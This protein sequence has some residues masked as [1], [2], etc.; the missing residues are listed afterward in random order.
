MQKQAKE[1]Y[2]KAKR[3]NERQP[4]SKKNIQSVFFVTLFLIFGFG[5]D[6]T[7]QLTRKNIF[8]NEKANN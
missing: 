5:S 4:R 2:Y 3:N 1:N 6:K 8:H 7:C